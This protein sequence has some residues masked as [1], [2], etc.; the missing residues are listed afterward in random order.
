MHRAALKKTAPI[1]FIGAFYFA[2]IL[3][4][5]LCPSGEQPTQHHK[6]K[7]GMQHSA[8]CLLACSS[9]V[10][11]EVAPPYLPSMPTLLGGLLIALSLFFLQFNVS[12]IRSRAPP[13]TQSTV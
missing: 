5:A 2:T 9:M 7:R 13:L 10:A 12:T 6:H 4:G 11:K 8:S 3:L 1:L